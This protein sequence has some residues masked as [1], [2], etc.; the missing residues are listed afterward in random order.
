MTYV[1]TC[2]PCGTKKLVNKRLASMDFPSF[3]INRGALRLLRWSRTRLGSAATIDGRIIRI[4]R[5]NDGIT[6][7]GAITSWAPIL[8][9]FA[10]SKMN[11][12]NIYIVLLQL[13]LYIHCFRLRGQYPW[14]SLWTIDQ[15]W[16]IFILELF[17]CLDATLQYCVNTLHVVQ[18]LVKTLRHTP[19]KK[20]KC[21]L[22]G[23]LK[24]IKPANIHDKYLLMSTL[25]SAILGTS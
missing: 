22:P 17:V 6:I 21:H 24:H 10:K 15:K 12:L 8:A 23:T 1:V 14:S 11:R 19:P 20:T 3:V 18:Q 25:E 13:Q 4:Q 9:L 2:S 16:T 7:A 5:T